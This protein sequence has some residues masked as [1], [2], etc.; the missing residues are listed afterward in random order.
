MDSKLSFVFIVVIIL[1]RSTI[2]IDPLPEVQLLFFFKYYYYYFFGFPGFKFSF[3]LSVII[4]ELFYRNQKS[5]EVTLRY[6]G[7][8]V[9]TV[10]LKFVSIY[11]S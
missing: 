7:R 11:I 3:F 6:R 2:S 8:S 10:L 9:P 5:R 4:P 1:F